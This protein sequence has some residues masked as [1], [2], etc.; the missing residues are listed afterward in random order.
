MVPLDYMLILTPSN[1]PTST[2]RDSD[3]MPHHLVPFFQFIT[4]ES[5]N[6]IPRVKNPHGSRMDHLVPHVNTQIGLSPKRGL[7]ALPSTCFPLSEETFLTAQWPRAG[8]KAVPICFRLIKTSHE[9][10]GLLLLSQS[11]QEIGG[12]AYIVRVRDWVYFSLLGRV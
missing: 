3:C 4:S 11:V 1:I 2:S 7:L 5:V 8:L 10:A 12:G 9:L 6:C